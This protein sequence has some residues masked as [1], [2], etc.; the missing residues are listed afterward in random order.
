MLY[1]MNM[2]FCH[3]QH[4]IPK[5]QMEQFF[6][7]FWLSQSWV[8]T[9]PGFAVLK[10]IHDDK[11]K[12]KKNKKKNKKKK[13]NKPQLPSRPS[14]A[15]KPNW[16]F[17]SFFMCVTCKSL[18]TN[19]PAVTAFVRKLPSERQ[20][21]ALLK[22]YDLRWI[23]ASLFLKRP[24]PSPPPTL[25]PP[26]THPPTPGDLQMLLCAVPRVLVF[27]T[28]YEFWILLQTN[29]VVDCLFSTFKT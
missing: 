5:S 17:F 13:W 24:A 23:H 14:S 12:N 6:W 15:P 2:C 29:W 1:F 9:D 25:H 18:W 22:L 20:L 27:H 19:G 28:L 7:G 8:V 3:F 10:E 26:S 21:R 16:L 11:K 4:Q